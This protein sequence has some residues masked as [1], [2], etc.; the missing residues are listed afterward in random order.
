MK[1]DLM[2]IHQEQEFTSHELSQIAELVES[3]RL[4]CGS[5]IKKQYER[6]LFK[7]YGQEPS[8]DKPSIP[9]PTSHDIDGLKVKIAQAIAKHEQ[10]KAE[11]SQAISPDEFFIFEKVRQDGKTNMLDIAR[12]RQLS[13]NRLSEDKIKTIIKNYSQIKARVTNGK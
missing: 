11:P 5:E 8:E 4:K 12:V 13:R 1:D 2:F 6:I 9:Y 3:Q 10:E 7:I